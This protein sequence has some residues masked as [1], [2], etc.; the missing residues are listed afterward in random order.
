MTAKGILDYARRELGYTESPA[1]SN[2]TKYGRWYGL[3]GQPWCMMF[4]MWAFDQ[5]GALD[6]LP[7]K[8]ASC[9]ALMRAAQSKGLW[10]TD[11][12]RPG[13][14][15]IYD[16][17]GGAVTD[18]CGLL[19]T[20]GATSVTAIEGNTAVGNDTNGGAVMRRT[21]IKS[22]VVGAVRPHYKEESMDIADL[23]DGQVIQLAYR[24]QN[25]LGKSPVS[26]ALQSELS[27]ALEKGITDGSSPNAYCTRAQAAVMAL[28]ASKQ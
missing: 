12:Y 24:M 26:S 2:R 21:R 27:E 16:F 15:L 4:I 1:G 28:R 22:Q 7:V 20:A 10:F 25:L 11:D 6:L 5:A 8:T 13:D 17:P 23:T 19:E 18:H 9:G 3:D 14:I